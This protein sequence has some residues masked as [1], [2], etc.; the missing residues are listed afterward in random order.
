MKLLVA[1]N[2]GAKRRP[3]SPMACAPAG[4][5][6]R[7]RPP[8]QPEVRSEMQLRRPGGLARARRPRQAAPSCPS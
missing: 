2:A 4:A 5:R 6:Q 8:L 7:A 1:A 3:G